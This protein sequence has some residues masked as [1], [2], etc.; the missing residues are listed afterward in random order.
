[1]EHVVLINGKKRSNLSV[2][3][4]ISLF[5][6]GLFETCLVENNKVRFWSKHFDRL[7]K[8]RAKLSINT[9]KESLWLKEINKAISSIKADKCVV[10][11]ILS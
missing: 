6:D 7:E 11:I 1:M 5:G 8:G 3:N 9:V 2:F 4:R 10:K